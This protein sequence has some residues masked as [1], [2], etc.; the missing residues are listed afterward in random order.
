M[1]HFEE[2]LYIEA[3]VATLDEIVGDL[4]QLPKFW[5]GLSEPEDLTGEKGIGSQAKF[6]QLLMGV[7]MHLTMRIAK[8]DHESD[9]ATVWRWE[10]EGTTSGWL[11]CRH[12]PKDGGTQITTEFEYSVP[13]SVL[14][15][16]A[17]R[18]LFERLQKRDFRH[19]L[20]NLKVL[21]EST[22]GTE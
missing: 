10:F 2:S 19:S 5:V 14:G 4:R 22:A 18:V 16:V 7:H 1:A 21:A 15:K 6:T 13:G 9:G 11:N 20:E 12:T 8:E 17:D 3:P